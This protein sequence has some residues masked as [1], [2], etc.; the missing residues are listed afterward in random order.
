M[1]NLQALLLLFLRY[2]TD[3]IRLLIM[4]WRFFFFF[5][6]VWGRGVFLLRRVYLLRRAVWLMRRGVCLPGVCHLRGLPSEAGGLPSRG[7]GVC[8]PQG[9]IGRHITVNKM[10]ERCKNITFPQ[11]RWQVGKWREFTFN[12][13][14]IQVIPWYY[15]DK[16]HPIS[17]IW[18]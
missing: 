9:V 8:L 14:A 1:I 18:S 6:H 10:T 3:I 17:W 16:M 12:T 11:L 7:G 4:V 5:V 2:S 13:S 15:N